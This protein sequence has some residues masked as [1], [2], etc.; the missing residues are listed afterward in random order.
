MIALLNRKENVVFIYTTSK[1]FVER[2]QGVRNLAA[3]E[4]ILNEY[5]PESYTFG[6]FT[7][8]HNWTAYSR[9]EEVLNK[10]KMISKLVEDTFMFNML[11]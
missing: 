5:E 9:Q 3:V 10:S 1:E 4:K 2:V 11:F 8:H 6:S 7:G